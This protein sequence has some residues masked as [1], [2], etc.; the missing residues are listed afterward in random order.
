MITNKPRSHMISPMFGN[1]PK[2]PGVLRNV[3][4]ARAITCLIGLTIYYIIF[5][6]QFSSIALV[7]TRQ[8]TF[9][10]KIN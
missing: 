2:V 5:Q 10:T 7:F 4:R 9:E 3:N 1:N 6:K 8:N